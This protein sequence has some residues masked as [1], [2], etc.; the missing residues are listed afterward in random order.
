[1]SAFQKNYIDRLLSNCEKE[2]LKTLSPVMKTAVTEVRDFW[3]S[4]LERRKTIP[5]ENNFAKSVEQ[6]GRWVKLKSTA[7]NPSADEWTNVG[8]LIYGY[9]KQLTWAKVGPFERAIRRGDLPET[10]RDTEDKVLSTLTHEHP[11]LD[12]VEDAIFR[13]V[14]QPPLIHFGHPTYIHLDEECY[15]QLYQSMILGIKV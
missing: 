9:D 2:L 15:Y 6:S 11:S 5:D 3:V 12:A 14:K 8:I 10:H 4:T 7:S 1:M 13:A